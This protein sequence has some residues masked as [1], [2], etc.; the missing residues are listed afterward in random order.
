MCLALRKS[1]RDSRGVYDHSLER[2][3]TFITDWLTLY[4]RTSAPDR[5]VTDVDCSSLCVIKVLP[6]YSTYGC[7]LGY[8]ALHI[9]IPQSI[10]LRVDSCGW[11]IST[12]A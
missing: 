5:T 10:R 4:F 8:S 3:N 12:Y 2:M 9:V 6:L 7:H 1:V 11:D